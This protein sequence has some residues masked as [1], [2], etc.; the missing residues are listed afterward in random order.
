MT[1][2][3]VIERL[4][5]LSVYYKVKEIFAPYPFVTVVDE[6]PT[7]EF[8]KGDLPLVSVEGLS[9]TSRSFELGNPLLQNHR[10]WK[11]NVFSDNNTQRSDL[12]YFLNANIQVAIP[13]YDYNEGFPPTVVDQT[14]LGALG[15]PST[16]TEV[17]RVHSQLVTTLYWRGELEIV[18][19]YSQAPGQ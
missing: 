13:V 6:F 3:M 12:L 2:P 18:T 15:V 14:Q 16:T 17:I 8:K 11:I 10:M 9:F 19:E 5:D 4:Q 1:I 7:G